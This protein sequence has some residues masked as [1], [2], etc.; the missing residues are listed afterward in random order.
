MKMAKFNVKGKETHIWFDDQCSAVLATKLVRELELAGAYVFRDR[1]KAF[2]DLRLALV[3]RDAG[4]I[5]YQEYADIE[6]YV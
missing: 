5:T 3:L 1:V 2:G 6:Q 4:V